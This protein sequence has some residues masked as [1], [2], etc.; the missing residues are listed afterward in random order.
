MYL[1][2]TRVREAGRMF[3]AAPLIASLVAAG[4]VQAQPPRI[5]SGPIE[6]PAVREAIDKSR[7]LLETW[8]ADNHIAGAAVAVAVD[9]RIVWSEGKGWADLELGVPATPRTRFR[10]GSVSKMLA[11]VALMRLV[12]QGRLD[13][14]APIQRYVPDF[15]VKPWPITA[16]HLAGHLSGIRHY[17]ESDFTADTPVG[18][19]E[20]FLTDRDAL[21]IFET[22]PL[23][24]EPG[25]RS[26]YSTYGYSVLAAAIAGAAGVS[27][28][29]VVHDL[30]VRPLGLRGISADHP[31]HLVPDRSKPY[32]YR[33]NERVTINAGFTDNSYKWAGGGYVATADDLVLLASALTGP[34]LLSVRSLEVMFTPQVLASGELATSG[35]APV[36]IGWRIDRDEQ[37]RRR[38]H[39]GGSLTGGG[40][41]LLTLPDEHVTVAVVTNQLPR[42]PEALASQVAAWFAGSSR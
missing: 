7:V 38:F 10:I 27:Y 24:F 3:P 2:L 21:R 11:A 13:L 8:L 35:A 36:G 4:A 29:Q 42:P 19:N 25:T 15:P 20:H 31:Y 22:D 32:V 1:Q 30:I 33:A 18:R 39:H 40:A 17:R 5:Q 28:Q 37:G 41:M 6:A 14:D 26:L 23:E 34:G 9:G 12:E 16:R